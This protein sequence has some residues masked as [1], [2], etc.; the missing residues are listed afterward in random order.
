MARMRQLTDDEIRAFEN[1][2]IKN[3]KGKSRRKKMSVLALFMLGL[4]SVEVR[5]IKVNDIIRHGEIV[6]WLVVRS[7]KTREARYRQIPVPDTIKRILLVNVRRDREFVAYSGKGGALTKQ[8]LWVEIR[9][10]F[11]LAGI[12]GAGSH[13]FRRTFIVK[14]SR[15]GVDIETIRQLVGHTSLRSTQEYL[16]SDHKRKKRAVG[17]MGKILEST[18]ISKKVENIY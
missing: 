3:F 15:S 8:W 17:V 16:V 1:A 18:M 10:I 9:K 11:K 12:C 4:R 5:S 6:E 14:L 2:I 13:S 7:A